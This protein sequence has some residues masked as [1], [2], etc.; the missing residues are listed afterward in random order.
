LGLGYEVESH[1]KDYILSQESDPKRI[2]IRVSD[3]EDEDENEEFVEE[4]GRGGDTLI[5]SD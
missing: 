2:G 1:M 5:K 4:D 3:N